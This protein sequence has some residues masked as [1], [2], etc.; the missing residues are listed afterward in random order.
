MTVV[1]SYFA[2]MMGVGLKMRTAVVVAVYRKGLSMSAAARRKYTAGQVSHEL[3]G[4]E[5]D[6]VLCT[7]TVP[8]YAAPADHQ[9]DVSGLPAV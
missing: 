2:Q 5:S 8:I 6:Q 7:Y 9:L 3:G 4:V 1:N